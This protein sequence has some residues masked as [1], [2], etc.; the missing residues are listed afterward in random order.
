MGYRAIIGNQYVNLWIDWNRLSIFVHDYWVILPIIV[1]SF[2]LQH[3]LQGWYP[4][5]PIFRSMGKRTWAELDHEKYALKVLKG[6]FNN[7]PRQ[8]DPENAE[9]IF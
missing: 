4:P 3:A 8:G 7:V 5:L 1:L 9:K 6:D 2:F